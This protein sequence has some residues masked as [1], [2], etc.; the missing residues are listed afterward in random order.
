MRQTHNTQCGSASEAVDLSA[1]NI[2][3]L[4]NCLNTAVYRILVLLLRV[5]GN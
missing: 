3:V 5:C 4:D 2:D 1:F